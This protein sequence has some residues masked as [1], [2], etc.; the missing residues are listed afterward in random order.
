VLGHASGANESRVGMVAWVQVGSSPPPTPGFEVVLVVA[1]L[2]IVGL[3]V[4]TATSAR[5]DS[6]A[7]GHPDPGEI[8]K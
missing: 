1:A 3:A 8:P 7:P 5:S 2:G 4:R 6:P